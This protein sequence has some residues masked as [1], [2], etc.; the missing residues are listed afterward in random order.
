MISKVNKLSV[1]Q[2]DGSVFSDGGDVYP[3]RTENGPA[4][5]ATIGH[6]VFSKVALL[7]LPDLD[8]RRVGGGHKP[9]PIRTD[10]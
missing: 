9:L 3:T 4:D 1:P 5:W 8:D 7:I 10:V 2:D 6:P